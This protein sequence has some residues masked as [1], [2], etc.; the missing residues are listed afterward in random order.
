[1]DKDDDNVSVKSKIMDG[2]YKSTLPVLVHDDKKY[3]SDVSSIR[4]GRSRASSRDYNAT[5]A[6]KSTQLDTKQRTRSNDSDD[7]PQGLLKEQTKSRDVKFADI[8]SSSDHS[9]ETYGSLPDRLDEKKMKI[10][11]YGLD[12]FCFELEA[13]EKKKFQELFQGNLS[14]FL[15]TTNAQFRRKLNQQVMLRCKFSKKK[16]I[17][18]R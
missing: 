8:D 7:S 9:S 2:D 1:M 11:K 15:K 17:F 14:T 16:R 10:M 12:T 5:S 6:L 4:G 18:Y 13:F 3:Q